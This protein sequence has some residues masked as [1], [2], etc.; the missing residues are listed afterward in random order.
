MHLDR[1]YW[2]TVGQPSAA[3]DSAMIADDSETFGAVVGGRVVLIHRDGRTVALPEPATAGKCASAA[4]SA[5]GQHLALASAGLRIID[6]F[7]GDDFVGPADEVCNLAWRKDGKQVATSHARNL[8]NLWG[9]AAEH[10]GAIPLP[11]RRKRWWVAFA[12]LGEALFAASYDM[13]PNAICACPPSGLPSK[14]IVP[15]ERWI[16]GLVTWEDR[17]IAAASDGSSHFELTAYSPELAVIKQAS[18]DCAITTLAACPEAH[19]LVAGTVNGS[20]WLL[21]GETLRIVC[22]R[23]VWTTPVRTVAACAQDCIVAGASD[24]RL[25]LLEVT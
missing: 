20:L 1:M 16:S 5:D 13:A 18:L 7:S 24:G 15:G 2:Y 3:V 21:D 22:E 23:P 4:L 19:L 17:V 9:T 10:L 25:A 8:L 12:A 14:V 6:L 11:Y